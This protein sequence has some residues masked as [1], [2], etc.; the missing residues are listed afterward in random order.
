M[1]PPHP[2]FGD[3]GAVALQAAK[4]VGGAV[5][6]LDSICNHVPFGK[7]PFVVSRRRRVA[8]AL[9]VGSSLVRLDARDRDGPAV[10]VVLEGREV[11]AHH[12]LA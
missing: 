5:T 4:E 9:N 7:L 10:A 1:L 8:P 12:R 2:R 11:D 3:V 6:P